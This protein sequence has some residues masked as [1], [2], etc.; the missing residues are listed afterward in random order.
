M[1]L[2]ESSLQLMLMGMGSVFVFLVLLVFSTMLMSFV[3]RK[4]SPV[5]APLMNT[6]DADIAAVAAVA[7]MRHTKSKTL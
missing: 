6:L 4:L 1:S 2:F 5:P 7:F 3:V